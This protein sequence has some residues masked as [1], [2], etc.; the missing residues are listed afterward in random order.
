MSAGQVVILVVKDYVG[1]LKFCVS[2]G[3]FLLFENVI[4]NMVLIV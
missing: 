4:T 3:K 1:H 2:L